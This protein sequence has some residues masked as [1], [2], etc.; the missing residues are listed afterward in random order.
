LN[1]NSPFIA[2]IC[3]SHA[4]KLLSI[5]AGVTNPFYAIAATHK[6]A[7]PVSGRDR[8]ALFIAARGTTKFGRVHAVEAPFDAVFP[9]GVTID[10]ASNPAGLAIF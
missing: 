8:Y 7:D 4:S 9:T 10:N 3:E 5:P 6:I 1:Q 2:A